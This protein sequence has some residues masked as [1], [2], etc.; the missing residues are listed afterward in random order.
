MLLIG[1]VSSTRVPM[2]VRKLG[3]WKSSADVQQGWRLVMAYEMGQPCE[4]EEAWLIRE[5]VLQRKIGILGFV[6][7]AGKT[8]CFGSVG[9]QCSPLQPC[10]F[11]L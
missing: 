8:Q 9:F 7:L 1:F 4:A 5:M 2:H 11:A 6:L 3:V 10:K